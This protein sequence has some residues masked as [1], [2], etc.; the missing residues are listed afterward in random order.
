M[1][2]S[3][4]AFSPA[5]IGALVLTSAMPTAAAP[6]GQPASRCSCVYFE[7][8]DFVR[9]FAMG[10]MDNTYLR[11]GAFLEATLLQAREDDAKR[12]PAA[13]R[14]QRPAPGHVYEF[15]VVRAWIRRG[16][17]SPS[18]T[19][20]LY[21]REMSTCPQP[22]WEPGRQYLVYVFRD[23][24]TLRTL[25]DCQR[26]NPSEAPAT[27]RAFSVLDSLLTRR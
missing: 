21:A 4:K 14:L 3:V 1:L 5:L 15:A 24:D 20:R 7:P 9:A 8:A 18:D 19:V 23:A 16:G 25:T 10:A 27:Q 6:C 2:M 11:D 13:D 12:R 17:V 22:H 26:A